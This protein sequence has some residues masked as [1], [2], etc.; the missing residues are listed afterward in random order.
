MNPITSTAYGVKLD[1]RVLDKNLNLV[2]KKLYISI[3][4]TIS[5]SPFL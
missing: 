5:L 2:G 4:T 1:S 3:I